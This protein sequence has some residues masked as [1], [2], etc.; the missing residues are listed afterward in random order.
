[1][2]EDKTLLNEMRYAGDLIGNRPF[3]T[4]VR[5]TG[6]V[7][8]FKGRNYIITVK[9]QQINF[10]SY[11]RFTRKLTHR[12]DFYLKVNDF[13]EFVYEVI[14]ERLIVLTIYTK[15]KTSLTMYMDKY[16]RNYYSLT[17]FYDFIE[18]LR[19]SGVSDGETVD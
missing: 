6:G 12:D 4:K 19:E 8:K 9:N 7:H 1:M 16:G 10:Y 17:N 11:G 5:K 14:S 15:N 13:K 2:S 18:Y 3:I